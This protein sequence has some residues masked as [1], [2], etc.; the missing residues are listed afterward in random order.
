VTHN[1]DGLGR[2]YIVPRRKILAIR[3]PE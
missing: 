3:K 1:C 2:R